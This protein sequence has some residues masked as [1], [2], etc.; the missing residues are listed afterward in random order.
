MGKR[1]TWLDRLL[2]QWRIRVALRELPRGARVLDVGTYDG[3]LFRL[4]G[5]RG[6]GID[7]KLA[8]AARIPGVRLVQGFFPADLPRLPVGSFD[9]VTA[10]A[11]IEHVPD[12]ELLAW[13][14]A[15]AR[16]IAPRGRLIMTVPA[17]VVDKILHVLMRLQLVAGM[18]AH[19]H[20]RFQ[21]SELDAIFAA[22]MWRRTKH[23][24]FQLGLNHLYLF[25]RLPDHARR[26][27]LLLNLLTSSHNGHRRPG[28]TTPR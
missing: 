24:V 27:S 20:H 16:L 25:E 13:A 3:K 11:V 18:E 6:I 1:M 7:P 28:T 5:A 21:P 22:P 12:D 26:R 23:R 17:P 10:L 4:A 8:V 19:Q 14:S 9:A 2:Q 15:L